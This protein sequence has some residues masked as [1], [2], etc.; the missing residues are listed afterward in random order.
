MTIIIVYVLTSSQNH[1]TPDVAEFQT[2]ERPPGHS[3]LPA[4]PV[5]TAP[6]CSAPGCL[7]WKPSRPLDVRVAGVSHRV[8][9]P[10]MLAR[11]ADTG[12]SDTSN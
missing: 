12:P 11:V 3:L 1:Q 10:R 8:C 5:A 2:T 4:S 9:R 6:T 7:S